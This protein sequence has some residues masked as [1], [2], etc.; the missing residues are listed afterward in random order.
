MLLRPPGRCEENI[1]WAASHSRITYRFEHTLLSLCKSM[2][3]KA[4]A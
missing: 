3:R 4:A 2:T 1:P